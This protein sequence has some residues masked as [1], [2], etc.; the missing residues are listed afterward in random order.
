M[1]DSKTNDGYY[2]LGLTT[3]QF[4]RHAVGV[5]RPIA[6]DTS[7]QQT[8][9]ESTEETV[10]ETQEN[11]QVGEITEEEHATHEIGEAPDDLLL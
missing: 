4:I 7:K 6:D 9:M 5:S 10:Q 8:V 11:V 2:E 1:F 3:A